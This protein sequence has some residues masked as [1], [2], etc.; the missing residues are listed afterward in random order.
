M[1]DSRGTTVGMKLRWKK[2]DGSDDGSMSVEGPIIHQMQTPPVDQRA[3]AL[4]WAIWSFG[5]DAPNQPADVIVA[6]AEVFWEYL[7]LS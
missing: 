2:S 6:R 3:K 1:L 7:V 4:E 5:T